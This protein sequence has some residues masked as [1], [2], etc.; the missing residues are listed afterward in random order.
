MAARV[1][2]CAALRG[3]A[4]Y[5]AHVLCYTALLDWTALALCTA[6]YLLY[7]YTL[8]H[9]PYA[10]ITGPLVVWAEHDPLPCCTVSCTLT[11]QGSVLPQTDC[12]CCLCVAAAGECGRL[13]SYHTVPAGCGHRC[14]FT[15][16]CSAHCPYHQV[17]DYSL[18]MSASWLCVTAGSLSRSALDGHEGTGLSLRY[19]GTPYTTPGAG[20]E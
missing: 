9:T 12:V 1:P 5:A 7:T 20:V 16:A 3:T 18:K 8:Q 6:C 17:C 4:L 19:S 14:V 11:R 15:L 13:E 10:D 2:Y